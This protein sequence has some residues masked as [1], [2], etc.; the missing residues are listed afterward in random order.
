MN[1]KNKIN[2]YNDIIMEDI[3]NLYIKLI[4]HLH[5]NIQI[6]PN[7]IISREILI[8]FTHINNY[9]IFDSKTNIQSTEN[10]EAFFGVT[11]QA[12]NV[13]KRI[14]N[15]KYLLNDEE[16][17]LIVKTLLRTKFGIGSFKIRLKDLQKLNI[18]SLNKSK[19]ACSKLEIK[20]KLQKFLD[21]KGRDFFI[22]SDLQ[23]L[24][25]I[26]STNINNT[27]RNIREC[28]FKMKSNAKLRLEENILENIN[29]EN[30]L[31]SEGYV[32]IFNNLLMNSRGD[33]WKFRFK[34]WTNYPKQIRTNNYG[35]QRYEISV[36][37]QN[38]PVHILVANNFIDNP[39]NYRYVR[40][41]DGN[42]LNITIDNLEWVKYPA[43]SRV[44]KGINSDDESWLNFILEN[45]IPNL[46]ISKLANELSK[47]ADE[48]K[49]FPNSKYKQGTVET[50]IRKYLEENNSIFPLFIINRDGS[51]IVSIDSEILCKI[52]EFNN[53]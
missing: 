13:K 7:D 17:D 36:N 19:V 3:D 46:R 52:T 22:T 34:K 39:S 49:L 45:F 12:L 33:V 51:N 44:I 27:K 14:L 38:Y 32:W 6:S 35:N 5:N 30:K 15:G 23:E 29:I 40:A 9:Y 20:N 4:M 11:Y 25:E 21:D 18:D 31:L 16:Y 24:S 41:K 37:S 43:V 8:Y 2:S 10:Y 26:L 53:S 47:L 50:I 28:S 42:Y 48:K 1:F